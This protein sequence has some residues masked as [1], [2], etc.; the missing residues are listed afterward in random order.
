[1]SHRALLEQAYAAFNAREIDAA[2]AL[3][4]PDGVWPNAMEGGVVVGQPAVRHYWTRQWAELDP[5]VDPIGFAEGRDG[6]LAVLVHQIVRDLSGA[7]LK[8]TIVQH[9]YAFDGDLIQSMVIVDSGPDLSVDGAAQRAVV[10]VIH[11]FMNCFDLKDWGTMAGLLA[12]ELRADYTQLRGE[13]VRMVTADDY[14][15]SRATSLVSV[16]THH[17]LANVDVLLF[18][19]TA[20]VRAA[21]L[22]YRRRDGTTFDSHAFYNFALAKHEGR[23]QIAGITQ[24]IF[25]NE[26]DPAIH[27]GAHR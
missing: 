14:V 7:V 13:P 1:M 9:A 2:L 23:W 20:A 3:M 15:R 4:R 17:L 18:G 8:D 22:I 25:W 21:S 11:R 16:T 24:K 10:Q 19:E 26:G 5:K 27:A 6:H 12:P